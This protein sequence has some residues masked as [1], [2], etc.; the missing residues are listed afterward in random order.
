M[1][2]FLGSSGDLRQATAVYVHAMGPTSLDEGGPGPPSELPRW[3]VLGWDVSRS[4]W[5]R[6]A[7]LLDLDLE[8][9]HFD[10]P[11][12]VWL[13]SDRPFR[14][15]APLVAV[16]QSLLEAHG[17]AALHVLS[18]RGHHFL[19]SVPVES[20]AFLGLAGLGRDGAEVGSEVPFAPWAGRPDR[21]RESAFVGTGM[22]LEFLAQ[23]AIRRCIPGEI[24]L[25]LT[26]VEPGSGAAGREIVS[27]DLSEY[28]D[29]LETR[30]VRVPFGPYLKAHRQAPPGLAPLL[31]SLHAIPWR[32]ALEDGLAA[33]RRPEA[34]AA[35]AARESAAIPSAPEGTAR[36][37]DS[38]RSSSVGAAHRFF[39]AQPMHPP[40][41]W[42]RTY[43]RTPLD[44][45]PSCARR[46]LDDRDGALLT[47][48]GIQLVVRVLLSL[49]WHPRHVAGLIRSRWE[50]SPGAAREWSVYSPARRADFY[51]RLF[52]SIFVTG[53]DELVSFNCRSQAERGGCPSGC[54]RNLLEFRD[55]LLER[56][57]HDRLAGGPVHG[58]FLPNSSAGLPGGDP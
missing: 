19:W 5:D 35:L 28:G 2:E 32:G 22:V 42:S 4:L 49:G 12:A 37:L 48:A 51:V 7:A 24:P 13:G 38:Y 36:L 27:L 55:S 57:R 53:L 39:Y 3:L 30:R 15:Q 17:I 16:L 18:G 34:V 44:V 21:E 45:L 54:P 29:P 33:M 43:D 11:L 20:A 10:A 46:V 56:R 26:A 14:A 47:P 9:V 58:L 41:A 23:T 25:E 31:P 6:R 1:T 8:Y 50:R 40:E 52:T